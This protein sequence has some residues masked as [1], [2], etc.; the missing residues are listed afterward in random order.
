VCEGITMEAVRRNRAPALVVLLLLAVAVGSIYFASLLPPYSP[1]QLNERFT[2]L[3]PNLWEIGGMKNFSVSNGFLKLFDST[4]ATHYFITNPKWRSPIPETRLQGSIEIS[5]NANAMT[6]SS[7]A[8]A[9]TDSWRAYAQNGMLELDLNGTTGGNAVHVQAALDPGWHSLVAESSADSL[10]ISLDG[11]AVAT[12][13]NWNGNLTR[14]ELGTGLQTVDGVPVQG[15]L[16]VN[17]VKADLQ[18]LVEP[19]TALALSVSDNAL[20]CRTASIELRN[21][22]GF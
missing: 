17:G 21:A 5:F 4:N 3:D 18:P 19:Q 15:V 7:L 20:G 9:S 11:R 2:S 14:V 8:V 12:A 16:S 10:K 6:N 1:Y 22:N 13:D